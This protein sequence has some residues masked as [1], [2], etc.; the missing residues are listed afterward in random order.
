MKLFIS[1]SGEYSGRVAECLKVWIPTIIQ[2]VEV[3]CSSE[4]IEK[5]EN[6]NSRLSEELEQSNF[7]V[8]CLTPENVLAPWIHFEAGALSKLSTSRAAAIMLG[9]NPS[10]I[11][12]P[13]ARFQ[14]TAFNRKDFYRLFHSINSSLESPLKQT[15]LDRAF[16]NSWEKL[17]HDIA[18]IVEDY[19]PHSPASAPERSKHDELSGNSDAIQE[20]LRLVRNLDNQLQFVRNFDNGRN[21]PTARP[22]PL[23]DSNYDEEIICLSCSN[24][25][26]YADKAMPIICKYVRSKST[27]AF[28]QTMLTG[29]GVAYLQIPKHLSTEFIHE[30]NEFAPGIEAKAV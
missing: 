22:A 18:V 30:I 29:C 17:E 23:P 26:S 24:F 7:G 3:F 16:E 5:G 4:D 21:T 19:P 6:W 12:G 2:S 15:T 25:K 28:L 9:I 14:H 10:D 11:K 8:V 13:L 27:Q 1:W 20:L